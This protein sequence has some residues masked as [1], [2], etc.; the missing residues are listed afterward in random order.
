[1]RHRRIAEH[2]EHTVRCIT[3]E[4]DC[5]TGEDRQRAFGAGEEGRHREVV[6]REQVLEAVSRYLSPER[7]ELGANRSQ[8]TVD[9]S[10][11]RVEGRR[12][13]SFATGEREPLARD[14]HDVESGDVVGHPAVPERA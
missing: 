13:R 4:I 8:L 5:G 14:R 6:L 9:D 3:Y 7:P 12:L 2:D 11:E 1:M 10:P